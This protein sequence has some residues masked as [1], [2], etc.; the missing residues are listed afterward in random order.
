M[1]F[2]E[3]AVARPSDIVIHRYEN[4]LVCCNGSIIQQVALT[5]CGMIYDIQLLRG[6]RFKD[7]MDTKMEVFYI[8]CPKCCKRWDTLDLQKD[9]FLAEMLR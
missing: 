1:I 7:M 4:F 5:C 6:I 8:T 9:F 2:E 3:D